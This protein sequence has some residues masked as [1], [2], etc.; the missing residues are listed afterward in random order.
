MPIPLIDEALELHDDST[1]EVVRRHDYEGHN[2][3]LTLLEVVEQARERGAVKC[4]DCNTRHATW[5]MFRCY[6]C[7]FW[8]CEDCAP[9]HFGE[10]RE[11][12]FSQD[13]D[14]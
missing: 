6:Y 10:S 13:G 11:G 8:I 1:L 12:W 9:E 2:R 4:I 14:V 3:L 7:G 5:R